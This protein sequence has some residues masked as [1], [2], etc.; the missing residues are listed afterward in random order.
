VLGAGLTVVA[1]TTALI[2][3]LAACTTDS[4]SS[5]NPPPE[6]SSAPSSPSEPVK[7]TF[8]VYGSPDEVAA[9]TDMARHFDS[10][11]ERA[12]VDV[13][14]WKGHDGLRTAV[15]RGDPLPDVFL[16]SR[17]D[18]RW[19]LDN[20]LTRP[21]DSLLD[22]RGVDFGD[23]YSRDALTAFS[24]DNRLQCMPYGVAPQVVFYNEDLVDFER[25]ELRGLEVPNDHKRWSWDEFVAAAEFAARPSKGTKGVSVEPT[26]PGI[27]PFVYSGGGDLFD[28]DSDP[29]SLAFSGEGT[30]AALQ[31]MLT[32]FR[33][34]KLTL[35]EE[36]LAEK[37]ALEWFEAGKLGMI[38]GSR[39]LVPQLR[40]VPALHWDVM[41]IPT[42]DSQ[43]TT[44]EISAL[45]ISATAVSPATAADFLVYATSTDAVTEVAKRG[46]LQPANQEVAY[47]DDFLQPDQPPLSAT[48][49]N[50]ALGKMAIPPLLDTWDDLDDV[51]A[52]YLQQLFYGAPILD[53]A[54]V[55]QDIDLASQPILNPE[56]ATPSPTDGTQSPSDAT[57]GSPTGSPSGY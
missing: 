33:D 50:D 4:S 47:S 34:P 52:P 32:L 12:E 1:V 37:P 55:G 10:T 53:L 19:Y 13:E 48:V 54:A 3:S 21:V 44:G 5:P 20:Q 46:Y 24:A 22:E 31:T 25:M 11:T 9:Y 28:D 18:M 23:V 8:G 16:V 41:P 40:K 42:I 51:V 38:T 30:Q 26:L 7:L 43:A 15:E 57:T 14:H 35:T 56:T 39:A 2:L 6:T 49:F 29:T 36:Q 45:C 27:A 17:R